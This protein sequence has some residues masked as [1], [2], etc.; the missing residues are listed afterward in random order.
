MFLFRTTQVVK[1]NVANTNVNLYTA[2]GSPKD[3]RNVLFF[4]NAAITSVNTSPALSTGSGWKGGSLVFIQNSNTITG[5][6]GANGANGAGGTGGQGGNSG[7]GHPGSTGGAGVTGST[8]GAAL[9]ANII[10]GLKIV[11]KNLGSI[12]G[13]AGGA[14]GAGGGGGGGGGGAGYG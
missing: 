6:T 2:A 13:G 9:F 8:G 1:L 12:I 3:A 11:L 5:S 4:N 14:G 10:T 7:T